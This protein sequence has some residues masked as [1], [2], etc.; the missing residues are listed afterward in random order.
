MIDVQNLAFHRFISPVLLDDAAAT[1]TVLDWEAYG[2]GAQAAACVLIVGAT[3]ILA[4]A[5]K[6]QTSDTLTNATTLGGTPVDVY[7]TDTT[8][9]TTLPIDTAD[10]TIHTV[11]WIRRAKT[12][13]YV[14][15][16]FTAGN[17]STGTYVC[18]FAAVGRLNKSP[19]SA[20]GVGA[21]YLLTH[22]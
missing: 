1:S 15:L 16:Q 19:Q 21:T 6:I 18:A 10:N 20:T 12:Q 5:F 22:A 9:A 4:A 3:D 13:R 8:P 7:D 2:D 17:G 11:A 14:Q